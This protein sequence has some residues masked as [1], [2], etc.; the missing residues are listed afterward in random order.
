MGSKFWSMTPT[1]CSYHTGTC[2]FLTRCPGKGKRGM[3]LVYKHSTSPHAAQSQLCQHAG[4][5]GSKFSE[6][7]FLSTIL[8]QKFTGLMPS[9]MGGNLRI[10]LND[11]PAVVA[12]HRE[13]YLRL[14]EERSSRWLLPSSSTS[15]SPP[16]SSGVCQ[17]SK[18]RRSPASRAS[19]PQ[20]WRAKSTRC[21][22]VTL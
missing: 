17:P 18:Q 10:Y 20:C 6:I 2:T 7:I 1:T 11:D 13:E 15:S 4:N 16:S 22:I 14:E 9:M 19:A 21:A 5:A 3:D 12:R 8:A